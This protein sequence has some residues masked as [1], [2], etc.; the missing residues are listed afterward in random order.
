MKR[1]H[2]DAVTQRHQPKLVHSTTTTMPFHHHHTFPPSSPP[3]STTYDTSRHDRHEQHHH[4]GLKLQKMRQTHEG[5]PEE[6]QVSMARSQAGRT[7]YTPFF[8]Y[9]IYYF[10]NLLP[11]HILQNTRN[12]PRRSFSLAQ[13]HR[14][15]LL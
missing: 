3:F 1:S 5:R 7:R 8:Y 13:T 6:D 4:N 12:M 11:T 9:F 2:H 15:C 14:T 10:T